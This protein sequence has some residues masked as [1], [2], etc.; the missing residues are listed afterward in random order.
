[1]KRLK[2]IKDNPD[3][4]LGFN[5][6]FELYRARVARRGGAGFALTVKPL[7][8]WAILCGAKDVL[9]YSWSTEL[10]GEIFIHSARSFTEKE[11]GEVLKFLF[12]VDEKLL[13]AAPEYK[14]LMRDWAGRICGRAELVDVL[15]PLPAEPTSPWHDEG[16]F[17]FK[18]DAPREFKVKPLYKGALKFFKLEPEIVR[19]L[20]AAK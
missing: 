9:N 17:G 8:A 4:G 12:S 16:S 1:M 6:S 3:E 15:P 2:N 10:R 5:S 13:D 14:A 11:Y 18:L 7:W 19:L 20:E